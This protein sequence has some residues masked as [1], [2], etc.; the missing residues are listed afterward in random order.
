MSF[1]FSIDSFKSMGQDYGSSLLILHESMYTYEFDNF[2]WHSW[3]MAWVWLDI[4]TENYIWSQMMVKS[5]GCLLEIHCWD[6]YQLWLL[7]WWLVLGRSLLVNI[8]F[9]DFMCFQCWH[10]RSCI[11]MSKSLRTSHRPKYK[12]SHPF[13]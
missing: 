8:I 5:S 12:S 11:D 7:Y 6:Y 13:S 1:L 9:L 10:H 2:G 4:G 3:I